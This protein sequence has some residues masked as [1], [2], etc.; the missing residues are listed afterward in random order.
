MAKILSFD[1][2]L[3]KIGN[4][5][6]GP[7]EAAPVGSDYKLVLTDASYHGFRLRSFNP[8]VTSGSWNDTDLTAM[9][10]AE[11]NDPEDYL[12]YSC[13]GHVQGQ[14]KPLTLIIANVSADTL[15]FK[16]GYGDGD[17]NYILYKTVGGIDT[18]IA[19]GTLRVYISYNEAT[20]NLT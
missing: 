16:Y 20:L 17:V 15:T 11:M 13:P 1:N 6:L 19:S 14:I 9:E 2:K 7:A 3:M 12:Y 18:Q 5:L 4:G 8:N 10:L